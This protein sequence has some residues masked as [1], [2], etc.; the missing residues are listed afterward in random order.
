MAL[1][2][3]CVEARRASNLPSPRSRWVSARW[4]YGRMT[5]AAWWLTAEVKGSARKY[6]SVFF[7]ATEVYPLWP[8]GTAAAA[9]FD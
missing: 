9:Y 2:C 7:V 3:R 5:T 8:L 4:A 1:R 6:V